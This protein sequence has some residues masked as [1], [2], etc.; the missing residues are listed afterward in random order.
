MAVWSI[1]MT[2][3]REIEQIEANLK[4]WFPAAFIAAATIGPYPILPQEQVLVSN[5]VAHRRNEFSTGR[6]LARKGLR[7]FGLPDAPIQ[8]GKL[9]NPL[10]PDSMIGTISHDGELC[11]VAIN[12][13]V[14]LGYSGLGL[15]LV[16][17]SSR[18]ENM[19]ELLPIFLT[20]ESELQAMH[21]LNISVDPALILFSI[22]E[23]VIK[24][25]SSH[26]YEFV[27]MREI[28]IH[29]SDKLRYKLSGRSVMGDIFSTRTDHYLLTAANAFSCS[30]S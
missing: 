16:K 28:E 7:F 21:H 19:A 14:A 23:S 15:D 9:R 25:L 26:L 2:L 22:K 30:E 8:I 10:W 13:K 12:Q 29:Y 24:A 5:A 4:Q 6:W 1:R 3:Q 17:L 18:V 27:D 11:A 20:H